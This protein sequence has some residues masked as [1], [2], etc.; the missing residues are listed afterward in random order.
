MWDIQIFGLE[1]VEERPILSAAAQKNAALL[2][3]CLAVLKLWWLPNEVTYSAVWVGPPWRQI[4]VT[5]RRRFLIHFA[6]GA[7]RCT[8]G[9]KFSD[10]SLAFAARGPR[11]W[12]ALALRRNRT[13]RPCRCASTFLDSKSD[14]SQICNCS[15]LVFTINGVKLISCTFL[16]SHPLETS[17]WGGR[18]HKTF[19]VSEQLFPLSLLML[20]LAPVAVTLSSLVTCK[21]TQPSPPPPSKHNAL[22][23]FEVNQSHDLVRHVRPSKFDLL[24]FWH[25]K[26]HPEVFSNIRCFHYKFLISE[27]RGNGN[28]PILTHSVN[29]AVLFKSASIVVHYNRFSG[30]L[31]L[32]CNRC[33]L[34]QCAKVCQNVAKNYWNI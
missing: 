24:V 30:T 23:L 18:R 33:S 9:D 13:T 1:R 20:L 34:Y 27:W 12:A 10:R 7:S 28:A 32:Y 25:L 15:L 8:S 2:W 4:T 3:W 5:T 6:A 17:I 22:I 26:N 11:R 29:D 14:I 21:K 31:C 16:K 19:C